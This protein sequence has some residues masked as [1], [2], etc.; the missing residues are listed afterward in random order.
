MCSYAIISFQL[1]GGGKG[2]GGTV[3]HC[4]TIIPLQFVSSITRISTGR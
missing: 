2:G 3:F 4:K 1:E